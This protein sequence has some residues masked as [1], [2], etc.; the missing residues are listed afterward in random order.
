ML[1]HLRI[2]ITVFRSEIPDVSG[3]ASGIK[4]YDSA[5]FFD[6]LLEVFSQI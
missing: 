3:S 5:R 2:A 1:D 6:T 4:L